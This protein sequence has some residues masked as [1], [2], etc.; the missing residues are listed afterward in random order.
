MG[1]NYAYT[2]VHKALQCTLTR[3]TALARVK[4]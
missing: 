2:M 4:A 1:A 3:H